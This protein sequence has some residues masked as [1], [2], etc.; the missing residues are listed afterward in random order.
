LDGSIN[1]GVCA[2]SK[3]SYFACA[4][5]PQAVGFAMAD[6][7]IS[8]SKADH[9]LASK[10]STFLEAEGWTTWWD[11]SLGAA[12]LYRDEIMKQLV[13]ARAVITIWTSNSIRSDWVRAEAGTAK[14]E[15]KL[16]PVKTSDVAYADIPLP[17]G[18]M[19]TENLESIELI[20]AAVVAQLAKPAVE[21]SAAGLLGKGFK[22]E[23]L[24]WWGIIGGAVTLF[25]TYSAALTLAPWAQVLVE[26]WRAWT[27]AFWLWAFGWSGIHLPPSWVPV[28]SFLS[29]GVLLTI[30]QAY[31]YRA[32]SRNKT[33]IDKYQ[34]TPFQLNSRRAFVVLVSILACMFGAVVFVLYPNS[35]FARL[36][37]LTTRSVGITK[38]ASEAW[39]FLL[40][41]APPL[42]I[43]IA[44]RHKEHAIVSVGLIGT[45]YYVIIAQRPNSDL[46]SGLTGIAMLWVLPVILFSVS[47]ASA[48]SRR[49]IFLAIGLT[50][51]I[52]LN[53]L[54]NLGRDDLRLG[55]NFGAEIADL[56]T[57]LGAAYE[58]F[59]LKG[60]E[61][62]KDEISRLRAS[63]P[64]LQRWLDSILHPFWILVLVIVLFAIRDAVRWLRSADADT[65]P[66]S[67]PGGEQRGVARR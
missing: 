14:K 17:F 16:I 35:W 34:V 67:A 54:S 61:R 2:Q 51:L 19:H 46:V 63:D 40:L 6:I 45:F 26:N 49:L 25:S 52:A 27:H 66:P 48:V 53:E 12:D 24:T 23:L 28:L 57:R 37:G 59:D 4:G 65:R 42:I 62:L 50:L 20:R 9:A 22:Y 8:Y 21:P 44:A 33:N 3:L 29:F 1:D 7:F 30:G 15:G 31:R 60:V 11:T 47:P 55:H 56:E 38:T 10:L 41:L 13:S 39:Q 64:K 18:E 58:D 36:V 5:A 32:T 43:F